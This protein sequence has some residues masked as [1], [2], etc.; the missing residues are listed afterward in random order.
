MPTS[1][2]TDEEWKNWKEGK[3]D[4][5][6]KASYCKNRN[7]MSVPQNGT[8]FPPT[9]KIAVKIPFQI[10]GVVLGKIEW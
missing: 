9:V 5:W 8:T 10:M 2:C 3:K 6:K 7:K 4:D 1:K